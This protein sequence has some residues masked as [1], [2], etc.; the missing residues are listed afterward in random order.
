MSKT[1]P[2]P[3]RGLTELESCVLAVIWRRG[4]CSAYVIRREFAGATSHYWSSSAGSIYPV[5]ERLEALGLVASEAT[6]DGRGSRNLTVTSEGLAAIRAWLAT[7]PH[8]SAPPDPIR[9]RAYFLDALPAA[10][11][12]SFL[13]RARAETRAVLAEIETRLVGEYSEAMERLADEGA[14]LALGARIAWLDAVAGQ[15]K[16]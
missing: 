14:A 16:R 13:R 9:T 12:A 10:A 8:A 11:R 5:T 4:P 6:G 7:L 3:H 15:L 1:K 2:A